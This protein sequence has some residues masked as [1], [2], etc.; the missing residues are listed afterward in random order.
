MM[1]FWTTYFKYIPIAVFLG[2]LIDVV[3]GDPRFLMHPVQVIGKVIEGL[4]KGLRKKSFFETRRDGE[5]GEC[6]KDCGKRGDLDKS[7][8]DYVL[9]IVEVIGVTGVTGAV[10]FGICYGAYLLN[11]YLLVAVMGVMCWQCIAAKSLRDAAMEVYRPLVKG[12][13]EGARK[14]VSMI[15]GRD[16]QSLDDKGITKA[17]VE[18][19]AENTNDGVICPLFYQMLGGPVLSYIYKAVSTMDSMIGYKNDRYMY[20][21][22]FAAKTDDVF[23]YIPAR[24]S[25]VFMIAGTAVLEMCAA[26]FG[27]KSAFRYSTKNSI[28][29]F[30]RD[31]YNHA[32]PNSAQCESA[33]AGALGLKLAGPASYFGKIH[34]KQFIG[35]ELR[36]IEPED[37][38]RSIVLMNMTLILFSIIYFCICIFVGM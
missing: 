27:A 7:F 3:L 36:A 29:I 23:A 13:V 26:M 5:S 38:R 20:F 22:R 30:I 15:V 37:I 1:E 19:V 17:A 4:E 16:T 32:S 11:R 35:D 25:A 12:D 24:L 21:G 2:I 6:E 33:C 34:D 31:R 8:V 14:A 18:T 10:S 28:K 9:G